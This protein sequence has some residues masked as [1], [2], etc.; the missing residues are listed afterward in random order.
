MITILITLFT[1]FFIGYSIY[2]F[3][4]IKQKSSLIKLST[5]VT[6]GMLV[7]YLIFLFILVAIYINLSNS[8]Y[9]F[10]TTYSAN[11]NQNT[12]SVVVGVDEKCD[13]VLSN[14]FSDR[15]HIVF[16]S[17]PK[18]TIEI[19]SNRRSA[20]V[21]NTLITLKKFGKKYKREIEVKNGD[22]LRLGYSDYKI[23][24]DD[25]RLTLNSLF[26]TPSIVNLFNIYS[27]TT[28]PNISQ[29]QSKGVIS[30]WWSFAVTLLITTLVTTL[31]IIILNN[32]I[33]KFSS[34]KERRFILYPYIY[35]SY[36]MLFLMLAS[37]INFTVLQ[38]FQFNVYNK[39]S[40]Y[41]IL[42]VYTI[43]LL[44]AIFAYWGYKKRFTYTIYFVISLIAIVGSILINQEYIYSSQYI[45]ALNKSALLTVLELIFIFV[46]FGFGFGRASRYLIEHKDSIFKSMQVN[47]KFITKLIG[48]SIFVVSSG[49]AVSF[50]FKEGAG[51]VLIEVL[52]LLIFFIVASVLLEGFNKG[53]KKIGLSF[54]ISFLIAILGV[55]VVFGLK[56]MGSVIQIAIA[57]FIIT[58]F[59]YNH[60]TKINFINRYV[61]VT[62]VVLMVAGGIFVGKY[63]H[64]N[65]RLDMWLAPFEQRLEV[66]NQFYIYYF[67]QIAR[68]LFLIKDAS[69][70]PNDFI[71]HSYIPLPNIHT[72]FIFALFVNVF[73]ILGFFAIIV[74]F[75][76]T[77]FSFENSITL[78]QNSKKDI[79]RF[80][81][82]VNV[83]FVAYLFSYMIINI[84]SV[85]QIFPLTDVP[86]PILTYARGVLI[87]FFTLYI[88]VGVINYIYLEY[89]SQNSRGGK[90]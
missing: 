12:H 74:A 8:N 82:G 64:D 41:T 89:I 30:I 90:V 2:I 43:M 15:E 20:I 68:G 59:F 83:I 61:L 85:L 57:L 48:W 32:L 86:F 9:S 10:K 75:L 60:L 76:V 28:L 13:I 72:D 6:V 27:T 16:Y 38:Y 18:P 49:V 69:I 62:L 70:F 53:S 37:I 84:L 17:K 55:G 50:G 78:F 88:F 52:K 36:F 73:G 19:V 63:I 40:L 3:L 14:P 5:K 77:I 33:A 11:I 67:D 22:I 23:Y 26:F 51:I 35:I 87:L 25:K 39:G 81:Y 42:L 54:Y 31:F 66:K 58:L 21:N 79:F 65:I 29:N 45:F 71:E 56:D 7:Q 24:F 1:L 47:V 46:V 34:I 80:I 4:A 44:N